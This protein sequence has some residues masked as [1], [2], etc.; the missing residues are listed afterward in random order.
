MDFAQP[1]VKSGADCPV[2]G[3]PDP[4]SEPTN[5]Y[6]LKMIRSRPREDWR[7][8]DEGYL[9]YHSRCLKL[10]IRLPK[11]HRWKKRRMSLQRWENK[12]ISDISQ[13]DMWSLSFRVWRV[14]FWTKNCVCGV[15]WCRKVRYPPPIRTVQ[16]RTSQVGAFASIQGGQWGFK[17][18]WPPKY[19]QIS[20]TKVL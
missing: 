15:L 6:Y 14:Y 4:Y 7:S 19:H 1:M 10:I 16:T 12:R 18:Y 11:I 3:G 5:Q 17:K 9:C 13:L 2:T 20:T 8:P